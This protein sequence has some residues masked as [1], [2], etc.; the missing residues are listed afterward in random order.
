MKCV[1]NPE[2]LAQ[3]AAGRGPV[4]VR[5]GEIAQYPGKVPTEAEQLAFVSAADKA[6]ADAKAITDKA[7]SDE[8]ARLATRRVELRDKLRFTEAEFADLLKLARQTG[9]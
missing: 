2:R 8:K 5:D 4:T 1:I 9:G 7:A 6:E 3:M